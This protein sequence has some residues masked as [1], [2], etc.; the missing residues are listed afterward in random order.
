MNDKDLLGL[1][2]IGFD[3]GTWTESTECV[4]ERLAHA[5]RAVDAP[6]VHILAH[7]TGA[8]FALK[9]LKRNPNLPVGR[10]LTLGSPL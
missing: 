10:V 6:R 8:L 2:M 3:Y 4:I 5:V 9:A 7:S 1:K